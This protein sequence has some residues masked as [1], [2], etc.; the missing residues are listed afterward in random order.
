MDKIRTLT[1]MSVTIAA[2]VGCLLHHQKKRYPSRPILHRSSTILCHSTRICNGPGL[3]YACLPLRPERG[4][5][6]LHQP[7]IDWK[8]STTP[9]KTNLGPKN[10]DLEEEFPFEMVPLKRGFLLHVPHPLRPRQVFEI[11]TQSAQSPFVSNW[12][13]ECPN[14]G[15]NSRGEAYHS[16]TTALRGSLFPLPVATSYPPHWTKPPPGVWC[17]SPS[18]NF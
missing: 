12:N 8:F 10:D 3:C 18:T 5:T 14:W 7:S 6:C 9:Q 11:F 2:G 16:N 13:F 17:S 15:P 1:T 4:A